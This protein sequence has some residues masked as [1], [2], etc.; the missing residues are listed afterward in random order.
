MEIELSNEF[1]ASPEELWSVLLDPEK[2]S[3]CV[4]GM[5]SVEVISDTEYKARIKVKIAFISANFTVSVTIA[6]MRP[7]TYLRAETSGEDST[8]G[9]AVKAVSEMHLTPLEN[10]K[11]E[12]Q[13][14]SKADVLG[15]LGSLGL[16]PMR[17]KAEQ[18]WKQ[19]CAKV[20]QQLNPPA[21]AEEGTGAGTGEGTG[22]GAV[23]DTAPGAAPASGGTAPASGG[24]APASGRE[25]AATAPG[26]P[27]APR[28][29]KGFFGRIFSPDDEETVRVEIEKNNTKV[30]LVYPKSHATQLLEW[31][32]GELG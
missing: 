23:A 7:H 10:G 25:V 30:V 4:P 15:R 13:V 3:S 29:R 5:Q 32:K 6:E 12:L 11:T 8:V 31:V 2:M 20:D 21:D 27:A 28:A 24:T 19:F 26:L 22:A 16:N 18:M 17:T 14:D 1:D 9:S